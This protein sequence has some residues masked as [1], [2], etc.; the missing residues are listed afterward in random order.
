MCVISVGIFSTSSPLAA[1]LHLHLSD[2]LHM[3]RVVPSSESPLKMPRRSL[4]TP[5]YMKPE[6][7]RLAAEKAKEQ[8]LAALKA[9]EERLA[10][11]KAE[12]ERLA[13]EKAEEMQLR[14]QSLEERLQSLVDTSTFVDE[15][16]AEMEEEPIRGPRRRSRTC[17]T[18]RRR[19]CTCR[20]SRRRSCT[21]R[22]SSSMSR[23]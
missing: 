14:T 3:A 2:S 22:T 6:E 20:T 10:A 19:S 9:E 23:G 21:C 17:R 12:E 16:F 4:I 11:L 13:A 15:V 8:R 7:E 1:L 18:S 5:T